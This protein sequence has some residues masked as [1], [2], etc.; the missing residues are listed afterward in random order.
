MIFAEFYPII[1]MQDFSCKEGSI[2]GRFLYLPSKST[3]FFTT[4]NK[5]ENKYAFVA[6]YL[7]PLDPFAEYGF[8]EGG[9]GFEDAYPPSPPSNGYVWSAQEVWSPTQFSS[10][11][12]DDGFF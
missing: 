12:T 9:G 4:K 1:I 10:F 3:R 11:T 5:T 6:F 2:Y 7:V 8:P